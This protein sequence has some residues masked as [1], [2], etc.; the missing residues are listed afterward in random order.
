MKE[1]KPIFAHP[2]PVYAEVTGGAGLRLERPVGKHL[3]IAPLK[4][5][6]IDAGL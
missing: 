1:I 2:D 6:V 4:C 3:C 5:K